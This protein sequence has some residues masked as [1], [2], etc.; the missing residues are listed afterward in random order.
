MA[1]FLVDFMDVP[2][3]RD[4]YA[5]VDFQ[6][7]E[8]EPYVTTGWSM[9]TR[10]GTTRGDGDATATLTSSSGDISW[11]TVTNAEDGLDYTRITW[12]FRP[13]IMGELASG[14]FVHDTVYIY[15]GRD[16]DFAGGILTTELGVIA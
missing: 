2:T 8:G 1:T 4:S 3:D 9:E 10:I 16:I 6:T 12:R 13:E 11:A 5:V 14:R 15:G 7:E